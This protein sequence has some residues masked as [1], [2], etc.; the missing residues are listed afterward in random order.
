VEALVKALLALV[1]LLSLPARLSP[2]DR[3]VQATL[4]RAVSGLE[5]E[6]ISPRQFERLAPRGNVPL[7]QQLQRRIQYPRYGAM[8][9]AFVLAYYGVDYRRNLQRLLLGGSEVS[10]RSRPQFHCHRLQR[11]R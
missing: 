9:L 7:W 5:S 3:A 4:R 8:D 10:Q 2:A 1:L 11:L 6:S